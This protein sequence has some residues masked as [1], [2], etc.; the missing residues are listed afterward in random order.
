[1]FSSNYLFQVFL[2]THLA[3]KQMIKNKKEQIPTSYNV[4]HKTTSLALNFKCFQE[5]KANIR[6]HLHEDS[7]VHKMHS[8]ILVLALDF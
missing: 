1:M 8:V 5:M 2:D 7:C 6:P 3:F 4:I